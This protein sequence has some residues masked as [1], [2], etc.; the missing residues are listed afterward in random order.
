MQIKRLEISGFKSLKKLN[1]KDLDHFGIIAGANGSGKS[2]I[3]DALKFISVCITQGLNNALIAYGGFEYIHCFRMRKEYARTLKFLIQIENLGNTSEYSLTIKNMDT[4]PYM[5]EYIMVNNHLLCERKD[6][7]KVFLYPLNDANENDKKTE[8]ISY[9]PNLPIINI[10]TVNPIYVLLSNVKLYRI[11]PVAAK[12]SSLLGWNS[13]CLDVN[14]QNI[15]KV[16]AELKKDKD[17]YEK[18]NEFMSLVVPGLNDISTERQELEI[19]TVLAFKE[20]G[21]GKRFPAHL[22]SDGTLYLLCLF[23]AVLHPQCQKGITLIEEPERGINPKPIEEL[24]AL[25]REQSSKEHFIFV[26]THN[27]TVVRFAQ[28]DELI[29]AYKENDITQLKWG[30]DYRHLV[31][32]MPLDTAWLSNMFGSGLPW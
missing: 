24:I 19:R 26:T 30:R 16:L 3:F 17:F 1:I 8:E 10:T 5:L 12:N 32:N 7:G 9:P 14:G 25:L 21:L 18:L 11:D 15:A 28:A 4:S 13:A 31:K 6:N 2:N 29:F 27:E 20:N 22:I 23:T